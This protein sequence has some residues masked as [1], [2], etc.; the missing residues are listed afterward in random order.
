MVDSIVGKTT[1][2]IRCHRSSDQ[3]ERVSEFAPAKYQKFLSY[4]TG[5]LSATSYQAGNASGF[6]LA[7]TVIQCLATVN[8][9]SYTAPNWQSTICVLAVVVVSGAFNIW[10][11][12]CFS[13]LNNISMVLH[14]TGLVAVV[15]TLWVL[16][17]HPP[18]SEVLLQFANEGG[19]STMP[20]SLMVVQINA[21]A[22]L[23]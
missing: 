14:I 20:L 11:S 22:S 18:A 23:G 4:T 13:I 6:F 1:S 21:I 7:G 8:Y 15:V 5:W 3:H 12:W 16:A 10:C 19:W 2:V 9:P 17:P